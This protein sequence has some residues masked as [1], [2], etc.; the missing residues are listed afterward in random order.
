M[1]VIKNHF[2]ECLKCENK[3][4]VLRFIDLFDYCNKD[5]EKFVIMERKG[6]IRGGCRGLPL[7]PI[8][9]SK[10]AHIN[11]HSWVFVSKNAVNKILKPA[12]K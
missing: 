3:E 8:Q 7:L 2:F 5:L 1:K 6:V 11:F 10:I 12:Q 9:H 4:A